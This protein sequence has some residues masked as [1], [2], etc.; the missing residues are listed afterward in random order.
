MQVPTT[1]GA[2]LGIPTHIV[3]TN[4]SLMIGNLTGSTGI[5]NAFNGTIRE[6][7]V[8]QTNLATGDMSGIFNSGVNISDP[9]LIGYWPLDEAL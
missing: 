2:A 1:L 9:N 8:Y 6:V 7:G 5:A 3:D 4:A